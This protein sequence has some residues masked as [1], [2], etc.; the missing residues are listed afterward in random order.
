MDHSAQPQAPQVNLATQQPAASTSTTVRVVLVH[1]TWGRGFP[2]PVPSVPGKPRWFEPGSPFSRDLL[3]LLRELGLSPVLEPPVFEWSGHNTLMARAEAAK[4]LLEVLRRTAPDPCLLVAHSHGGNVALKALDELAL[5]DPVEI[6]RVRL[7]TLSTPFVG[8]Y[9]PAAGTWNVERIMAAGFAL[10]LGFALGTLNRLIPELPVW[11]PYALAAVPYLVAARI[12]FAIR[13]EHKAMSVGSAADCLAG[14]LYTGNKCFVLADDPPHALVLR[15]VE[16]E[17]SLAIGMAAALGRLLQL[18]RDV[19]IR[20][21]HG[22]FRA[23][24]VMGALLAL[25]VGFLASYDTL[26][27]AGL[28]SGSPPVETMRLIGTIAA[29]LAVVPPLLLGAFAAIARML[30][31]FAAGE[32]L[33]W[34]PHLEVSVATAPDLSVRSRLIGDRGVSIVTV[35]RRGRQLKHIRHQIYDDPEVMHPVAAWLPDA[36]FNEIHAAQE[37]RR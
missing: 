30:T 10:L 34:M 15:G 2:E 28:F 3:T 25:F 14:R 26:V 31:G 29:V 4:Q 7:I 32:E 35:P 1:G 17:A 16:D 9:W 11:L 21:Y 18:M 6:R 36:F 5:R 22:R 19:S 27:R 8:L 37:T 13:E 20:L 12:Y 24:M 33:K 23:A